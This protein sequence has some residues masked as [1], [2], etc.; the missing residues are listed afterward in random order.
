V[1]RAP[2]VVIDTSVWINGRTCADTILAVGAGVAEDFWS[3]QI[4]GDLTR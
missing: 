3:A 1:G 2:R 4:V